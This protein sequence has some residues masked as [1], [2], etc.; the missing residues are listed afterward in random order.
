MKTTDTVRMESAVW[1]VRN[2]MPAT[3]NYGPLT[4]AALAIAL[5]VEWFVVGPSD[6]SWSSFVGQLAGA[7]AVLLLSVA[8]VLISVLPWVEAWFDGIDHAAIWHRRFALVGLLLVVVPHTLLSVG[9]GQGKVLGGL[10]MAGLIA[11]ALWAVLPRWRAMLSWTRRSRTAFPARKPCVTTGRLRVWTRKVFG[12]YERW[13]LMHK[14]TGL[15]LAAGVVHG[16]MDGSAFHSPVLRWTYLGISGTGLATYVYRETIA[17]FFVPMHDY[18]VSSVSVI[19][20]GT[21]ELALKPLGRPMTFIPGQFAMLYME[22]KSGWRRHPFTMSGAPDDGVLRFTIKALGDDTGE[23]QD[24]V[25]PGMPAVVSGPH[26][27]FQHTRG[28]GHQ[29]WIA[30]GIG[31]TPFLSWLRALD[32]HPLAAQVDFYYSTDGPA[33][34]VAE[35]TQIAATHPN[36]RVHFRDSRTDGRITPNDVLAGAP[37]SASGVSV[38]LCGPTPMVKGLAQGPQGLRKAGVPSRN[39]YREHFDWR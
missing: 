36:L 15:F 29:I 19:G 7:E 9:K 27:R 12:G 26:G 14:L 34:F 39:I 18:Q 4:V 25:Q 24:L 30:G 2:L 11:L 1:L 5:A 33:P 13:R 16:Y 8:I 21:T 32:S 23:L 31:I 3:R 38:F 28:T 6:G 10:G 35:I 20:P 37:G 22:G 17:R